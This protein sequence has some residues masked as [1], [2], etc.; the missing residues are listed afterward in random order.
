MCS[1]DLADFDG[2]Y[3]GY[4]ASADQEKTLEGIIDTLAGEKTKI[5][6]DPVM[7]DNGEYYSNH[8][9][10]MCLAFRRLCARADIITPNITEAAL[11]TDT[12]YRQGPHDEKYIERLLTGLKEYCDGIIAITGVQ[13]EIGSVGVVVLDTKT[14]ERNVAMRPIAP[15]VFHGTGDIF[16]S[17][18]SSLVIRGDRKS[19]V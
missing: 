15:G 7:A 5:I 11:L 13:T 3:S 6:V 10:E 19:V 2:I 12:E 4:L 1:S 9:K 16:A 14:G 18:F 17:S 8:G